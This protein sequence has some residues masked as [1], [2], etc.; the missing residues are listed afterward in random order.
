MKLDIPVLVIDFEPQI[1]TEMMPFGDLLEV[2]AVIKLIQGRLPP[3]PIDPVVL[4]R[5]C[6]DE[7]WDLMTECWRFNASERPS[8]DEVKR[9]MTLEDAAST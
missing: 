9:R 4:E 5:G 8:M 6:G 7:I 2:Q 1:F 3:R